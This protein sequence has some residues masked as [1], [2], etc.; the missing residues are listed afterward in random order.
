[1]TACSG[2][3]GAA[4]VPGEHLRAGPPVQLHE[5]TFGAAPVEED[6]AEGVPS[7]RTRRVQRIR[8]AILPG[9]SGCGTFVLMVTRRVAISGLVCDA[10]HIVRIR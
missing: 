4:A 8:V 10:R 1:M 7:S 5:V 3:A 6:V 9:R 2:A